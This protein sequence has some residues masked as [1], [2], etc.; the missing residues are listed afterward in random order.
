[1][2]APVK[3]RA[4]AG[5]SK[6]S[7]LAFELPHDAPRPGTAA[8]DT[9]PVKVFVPITDEMLED[10]SFDEPLVPYQPGRLLF[11]QVAVA[12][13]QSRCST[14]VSPFTTPSSA[15]L[16][17]LSSSTYWAGPSLG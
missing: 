3:P 9:G 17:P 4:M 5:P 2:Y 13:P 14:S 12:D 8:A 6:A 1:M 10:G 7:P 15:A 16:P 11:S